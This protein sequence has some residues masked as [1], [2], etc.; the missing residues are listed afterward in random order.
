M[1]YTVK[2]LA[3][4]SGVS[5]R[6]LHWYDEIGLLKPS[7][8]GANNYRY[9]EEEQL[10]RLQQIL[11]FKELGFALNDIQKLLLQ[12][13]FDNI[14]ALKSH[15]KILEDELV[16]KNNLIDTI[17]KTI[18]HLEGKKLMKDEELYYGFDSNRQKEYEEYLINRLGDKVEDII[19]DT[20]KKMKNWSKEQWDDF[21][22]EWNTICS[23]LALLLEKNLA[24]DAPEVQKIIQRHFQW[25]P[26]KGSC[27]KE[28]YIGLGQGYTGFEWK[29]AFIKYDEHHPRLANFMAEAMEFYANKNL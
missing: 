5:V 8:K 20:N 17:D 1:A 11:F 24:V 16:R 26:W 25:L 6:T 18:Q 7:E 2:E 13:D 15:R 9:Y 3:K 14:K 10:L 28:A 12:N 27:T 4:L 23:E 29:K 22:L 19:R 21:G